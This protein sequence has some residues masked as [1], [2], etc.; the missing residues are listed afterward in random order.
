M[1]LCGRHAAS[2]S[3]FFKVASAS[4]QATDRSCQDGA[5]AANFK[6]NGMLPSL[7]CKLAK[8]PSTRPEACSVEEA[9]VEASAVPSCFLPSCCFFWFGGKLL[10][11]LCT[12]SPKARWKLLAVACQRLATA[13]EA[14][15]IFEAGSSTSLVKLLLSKLGHWMVRA[16]LSLQAA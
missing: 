6:C 3:C 1:S 2:A 5:Q 16:K 7:L 14:R 8:L 4:R 15:G 9:A 11:V 13:G 12:T 10:C